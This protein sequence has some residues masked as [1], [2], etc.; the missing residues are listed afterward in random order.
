MTT[1]NKS[2]EEQDIYNDSHQ[3]LTSVDI[4]PNNTQSMVAGMLQTAWKFRLLF[5]S[6]RR[7]VV[8][9]ITASYMHWNK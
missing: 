2:P 6:R 1:P 8:V 4:L 5:A 3:A 9:N 7:D